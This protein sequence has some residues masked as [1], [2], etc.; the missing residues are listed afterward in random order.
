[1]LNFLHY[2]ITP[3]K[4]L[5]RVE[6]GRNFLYRCKDRRHYWSRRRLQSKTLIM[7]SCSASWDYQGTLNS[8]NWD[9][10]E[11]IGS[12]DCPRKY[13]SIYSEVQITLQVHKSSCIAVH[14]GFSNTSNNFSEAFLILYC[15][16]GIEDSVTRSGAHLEDYWYGRTLCTILPHALIVAYILDPSGWKYCNF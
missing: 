8:D 7:F 3:P 2:S 12:Q 14:Y 9:P 10:P 1:M 6:Y 11:R 16:I 5:E 4:C 13:S 15:G